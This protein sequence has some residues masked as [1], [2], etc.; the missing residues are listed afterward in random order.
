VP[1][2]VL[3]D[4]A[5]DIVHTSGPAAL[6]FATLGAAV[7]LAAST[8][9]QRFGTKENLLRAALLHAWD[10][11]DEQTSAAMAAASAD[12]RGVVDVLVALSG[13]YT[14]SDYADQLMVLREDLRDRALRTRG[15]RWI[16]RLA[17][18]IETR[19]QHAPGGADG[20]G[21]LVV[22]HW[23]GTLTVWSFMRTGRVQP[24]VRAS[25]DELLQRLMHA[26]GT[27]SPRR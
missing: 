24:T 17:A 3:L 9:V 27:S 16:A 10:R 6:S 5:L 13:Q 7:G 21:T 20:L 22:A 14:A 8:V 11:L 23:Q 2:D 19:L 4:A 26:P 12:E 1:D 15:K 18:D 25:L